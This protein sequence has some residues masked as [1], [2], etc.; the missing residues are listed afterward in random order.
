LRRGKAFPAITVEREGMGIEEIEMGLLCPKKRSMN[1]VQ[2]STMRKI[3]G[4]NSSYIYTVDLAYMCKER[5]KVL[6]QTLKGWT[7]NRGVQPRLGI[8][9]TPAPGNRKLDLFHLEAGGLLGF[10]G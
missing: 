8:I 3:S 9:P 1:A 6:G 10:T 4:E 2:Y 7:C 5:Y